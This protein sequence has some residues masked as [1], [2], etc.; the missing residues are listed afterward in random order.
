MS[1]EHFN[2]D[3]FASEVSGGKGTFL[4]DYWAPWCGPCRAMSGVVD[5]VADEVQ[6]KARVVK[7]NVDEAPGAAGQYEVQSIPTFLLFRDG[8]VQERVSGV[9]PKQRLLDLIDAHTN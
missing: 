3:H 4:V 9:V 5:E 1:A 8:E 7:V 2:D 6:G